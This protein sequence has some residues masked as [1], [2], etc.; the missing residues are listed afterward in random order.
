LYAGNRTTAI[1]NND[2]D[3]DGYELL[4][5]VVWPELSELIEAAA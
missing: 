5:A 4:A 3:V 1:L 2:L